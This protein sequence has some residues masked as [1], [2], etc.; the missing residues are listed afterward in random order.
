MA[1][2]VV[3]LHPAAGPVSTADFAG[4]LVGSRMRGVDP[5]TPG[6]K[7]QTGKVAPNLAAATHGF[8]DVLP[9]DAPI[10]KRFQLILRSVPPSCEVVAA[11]TALFNV[12]APNPPAAHPQRATGDL[13]VE[14]TRGATGS[15][16]KRR[17]FTRGASC[18][19]TPRQRSL[20][21]RPQPRRG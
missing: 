17:I 6:W 1:I 12:G 8:P 20:T 11:V 21:T 16:P 2:G 4:A 13:R 19:A 9:A 7:A 15:I 5:S 3:K 10:L 14:I 18:P